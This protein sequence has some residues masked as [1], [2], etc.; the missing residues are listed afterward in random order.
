[1]R[2]DTGAKL[3]PLPGLFKITQA[4]MSPAPGREPASRPSQPARA[5]GC[6]A[7]VTRASARRGRATRAPQGSGCTA[8]RRRP[9]HSQPDN[10]VPCGCRI[11][12]APAQQQI[13]AEQGQQRNKRVHSGFAAVPQEERVDRREERGPDTASSGG[14]RPL[15]RRQSCKRPSHRNQQRRGDGRGKAQD[16]LRFGRPAGSKRPGGQNRRTGVGQLVATLVSAIIQHDLP[17]AEGRARL[18]PRVA[19]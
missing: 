10:A 9:V 17:H 2:S 16:E 4:A 3:V 11:S 1:M 6:A 8:G 18:T 15:P 5:A 14:S 13:G 7:R 12:L 19:G